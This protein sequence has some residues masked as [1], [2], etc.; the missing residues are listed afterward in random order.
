MRD[1]DEMSAE[2]SYAQRKAVERGRT[3]WLQVLD[4]AVL[5]AIVVAVIIGVAWYLGKL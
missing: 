3:F 5:S 1:H 4:H 2:L